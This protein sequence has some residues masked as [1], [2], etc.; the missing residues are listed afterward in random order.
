MPVRSKQEHMDIQETTATQKDNRVV[1]ILYSY[2]KCGY[3]AESWAREIEAASSS[4]VKFI[5]FNHERFLDSQFYLRAQLLDNLYYDRNPGLM[6]LYA[7]V[8]SRVRGEGIDALIV[9]NCP[10][11]HPDW[12]RGLSTYKVLRT[13]DGPLC[14]YDRDFAYVHAYDHVLYHSPAYS[15]HMGME[16]KLRYVG[17]K[18][19][20]F[21]PIGLFD[22]AYDSG[23]SE[24]SLFGRRR[25]IDVIF[26]G[27]QHVGKMPLLAKVKK[28]FGSRCQMYGLSSLKRNL[29]FNLRHGFPA[30]VRPVAFERYIPLYQRAK[31]GFNLH[32]RGKYTVGSFRLFELP[33]NGVMQIS[34][35]GEYLDRFFK[36]GEE[37]VRYEKADELIDRIQYYLTH[38]EERECIARKGYHRVLTDYRFKPSLQRVGLLIADQLLCKRYSDVVGQCE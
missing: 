35:G 10:P 8:E 1:K 28:A 29:Y 11:Y 31:I 15:R 32:N 4:E 33:A 5:P 20:E 3:E 14:A 21:W 23:I 12:L 22:S 16:E 38:D 24:Q 34:D 36:V 30:W 17:A 26:I 6:R 18:R 27:A 37:I 13:S 9:D 7:E 2:N 25:D 19:T